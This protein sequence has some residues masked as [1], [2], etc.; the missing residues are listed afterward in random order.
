MKGSVTKLEN[1]DIPLSTSLSKRA[2]LIINPVSG[3][4]LVIKYIPCIIRALMDKGYL[5][6]TM[7][8]A[9]RGDATEFAAQ[10]GRDYDLICCTGGDGTLN[11]TLSGLARESLDVPLGYIPCGSTNDFA[12]SHFLSTDIDRAALN[13]AGGER[14]RYD[15]GRFGD[16]YFSYVAAFGAFSWLS[17]TTDQNLKNMFGH[18][19]YILDAITSTYKIKPIHVKFRTADSV[20]EDDYIFGAICNSTSIAGTIT[21]PSNLVNTRDGVFEVMLIKMP[22][23]ITELDT[24]VRGVLAQDYSS[25]LID[26]FQA[27]ELDIDNPHGLEWALDG[28][29]AATYDTVHFSILPGFLNLQG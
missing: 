26:F 11:E 15:V 8:T 5:V 22:R 7:I 23:T 25:P 27:T 14:R 10:L 28:E 4:K 24:I 1:S 3:K 21:L 6:T 17:Y 12:A 2:M 18:T 19:A 9:K 13:M 20:H 16:Y 29:C